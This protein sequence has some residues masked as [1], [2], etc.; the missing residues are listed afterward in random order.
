MLFSGVR[1]IEIINFHNS[2]QSVMWKKEIFFS[3]DSDFLRMVGDE[4]NN[5]VFQINIWFTI[6]NTRSNSDEEN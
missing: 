6:L 4:K 5:T 3:L 1:Q 2:R